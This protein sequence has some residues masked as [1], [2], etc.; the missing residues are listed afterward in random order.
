[1]PV[2]IKE[3]NLKAFGPFTDYLISFEN[4]GTLN[5]IYG[6]NEAGKSTVLRAIRDFLYGIPSRTSDDHLHHSQKLLIEALLEMGDGSEIRLTRRKGI[7]K[8]LLDEDGQSVDESLLQQYLGSINRESFNLMFGMDHYSLRKGGEN[9]LEGRGALGETLFEAASGISGLRNLFRELEK[10]AGALFKPSGSNPPMNQNIKLYRETKKKIS[11]L[12]L[13][14][15][16]WKDLE[17]RYQEEKRRVDELKAKERELMKE[18]SRLERLKNTLPLLARRKEYLEEINSLGDVPLLSPDFKEERLE[19]INK[20]NTARRHQREAGEEIKDLK[21]KLEQID[22]HEEILKYGE[23]IS[24]LYRRLD[25]YHNHLEEIP[26]REGEKKE[27]QEE[28]LALLRQLNPGL[29]SL[30]EAESLRLS[31]EQMEEMK[32]LIKDYPLLNENY[33]SARKEAERLQDS[34]KKKNREKEEIG[35]QKNFQNLQNALTRARK[36]GDLEGEVKRIRSRV[37]SLEERLNK[38]VNSLNLWSGTLEEL[39]ALPLP[40]SETVRSFEGQFQEVEKK[41]SRIEERIQ[42][43]E[44]KLVDCK[45]QLTSQEYQVPTEEEL[46]EARKHR[47]WGWHLVRRAWL[48]GRREEEEEREFNRNHPLEVAYELSVNKADDVA[49]QLRH[50]ASRV[51]HKKLLLKEMEKSRG[52]IQELKNKKENIE[53][54]RGKLKER[55]AEAWQEARITPLNPAEMLSWLSLCQ[56]IKGEIYKLQ[57]DRDVEKD[58]VERIDNH[59]KEINKELEKM[60]EEGVREGETLERL[61]DRAQD[62]CEKYREAENEMKRIQEVSREIEENLKSVYRQGKEARQALD[63]WKERWSRI[64]KKAGL[65]ETTTTETAASYLDKL[66]EL[67]QKKAEIARKEASLEKMREYSA[68][69]EARLK[70]LLD[71]LAP[72]LIQVPREHAASQLQA[73]VNKAQRDKDQ[74]ESLKDQLQKARANYKKAQRAMEEAEEGL[75]RLMDQAGCQKEEEL[76]QAEEKSQRLVKLQEGIKG[77]EDQIL[78]VGGGLSLEEIILEAQGVDGDALPGELENINQELEANRIELEELNR[79]FGATRKEY[80]EKIK[81]ASLEAVEAAEEAQGILARLKNQTEE[82]A[83]LRL[84]S[85]LLRRGID[86]YREENQSPI[87]KKAGDYFARLTGGAFSSL[88]VDFDEKDNPVIRGLRPSG[89]DVGVEGMSDGTLDQLYL[90]LRLASLEKYLEEKEP[91]PFILDDLLVNFDDIRAAETLKVLGEFAQK[92]QVLFFTHHRSMLELADKT[93]QCINL[94]TY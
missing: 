9:L 57:E 73:R 49:D 52:T 23:D 37:N 33:N 90:S 44:D 94:L 14:P 27:L 69:F 63:S 62:I 76:P 81:G 30:E 47:H 82:Y 38:K 3:L 87:I 78:S 68:D 12:S 26:A 31:H 34:L 53:K 15:Q 16:E 18:K 39:L 4:R 89:K 42:E 24:A 1:M 40:L 92:T 56:E 2:R 28:A 6:L 8:T 46:E 83:R 55:W 70:E 84:A 19:F 32:N 25:T 11:D 22:V 58:L 67:F 61:I 91:L 21:G 59:R 74:Q 88:K 20:R 93:T 35:P 36:G 86:R 80:E 7:K 45:E 71:K 41:I 54:E 60:G 65:S 5:L 17:D 64:L 10:E 85:I 50:E 77:L 72:D 75:R 13:K 51:E 66:E 29:S 79:T 43:E 48:E